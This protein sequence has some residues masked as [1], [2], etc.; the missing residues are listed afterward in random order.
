MDSGRRDTWWM[1]KVFHRGKG[2]YQA[3]VNLDPSGFDL[4]KRFCR[5]ES[6]ADKAKEALTCAQK[7]LVRRA[8]PVVP[9]LKAWKAGL[10]CNE[11][12]LTGSLGCWRRR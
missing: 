4:D 9:V 2:R 11:E 8:G 5:M 12:K 1:F 10:L 6:T 3:C 7:E